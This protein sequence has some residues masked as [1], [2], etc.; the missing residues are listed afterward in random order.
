[1]YD[2]NDSDPSTETDDVI[3]DLKYA[4]DRYIGSQAVV[5]KEAYLTYNGRPMIFIFPKGDHAD[6]A[7]VRQAR[8][9]QAP[10]GR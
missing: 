3:S 8:A 6:W 9:R 1:M 5:P 4:Y 7:R 10:A 2:E